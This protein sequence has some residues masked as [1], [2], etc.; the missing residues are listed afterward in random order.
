MVSVAACRLKGRCFKF[1][2]VLLFP[3]LFTDY[4]LIGHGGVALSKRAECRARGCEVKTNVVKTEI[5]L[6]A[7][8]S[9]V[10]MVRSLYNLNACRTL[11]II[12]LFYISL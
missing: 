1:V 8:R 10:S 5:F 4:G 11:L 9:P 7:F 6:G 2:F 12:S 3:A